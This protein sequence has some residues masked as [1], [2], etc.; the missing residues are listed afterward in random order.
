MKDLTS[1]NLYK[2][3]ILFAVPLVLAGLFSQAYGLV[4]TMIAG[5]YLGAEGL[6]AIGATAQAVSLLSSLF[7]G[8]SAGYGVYIGGL[9]GARQ[10]SRIRRE[11]ATVIPALMLVE[12]AV[13]LLTVVFHRPLLSLLQVDPAV[14]QEAG[15]YF[16][17]YMGGLFLILQNN[18]FLAVFNAL[19]SS[20]F[21][22]GMSVVAAVLNVGGNLLSVTV[23]DW[24]VAGV[25]VSSVFAALVV[26]VGYLLKLRGYFREMGVAGEPLRPAWDSLRRCFGYGAPVALQ[27]TAMYVAGFV[28]SPLINGLGASASASY[29]V[30][31]RLYEINAAIYQNS[32]KTVS[33][34]AAQCVGAGK[35]AGLRRGLGV[36]FLQGVV[37]VL[38]TLL[39]CCLC[40][41]PICALF[42]PEGF[43]GEAMTYAVRFARLYLPLVVFNVV[44]NLFHAFFRGVAAMRWLVIATV[45]ASVLRIVASLVLIPLWGMDGLFAG[46]VFSWVG[47]V[48]L[49]LLVYGLLFSSPEKLARRLCRITRHIGR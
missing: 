5:Q 3:F 8:F 35:Y 26:N 6:A 45:Y 27:Q 15:L 19:G 20:G 31:M 2:N 46:W 25:A 7:W 30:V 12:L 14:R 44:N 1:G 38:P 16:C 33:N 18:T 17:I 36:G 32:A 10:Y 11:L 22:F 47:E 13:G 21:P 43:V 4:D 23:L 37:F 28:I 40:A 34:Y 9:F 39:I 48:A 42:F 41:R 49:V 29:T 24:G